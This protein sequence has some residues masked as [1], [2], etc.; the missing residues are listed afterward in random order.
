V[1]DIGPQGPKEPEN[2]AKG[3][4]AG[5][6]G[7]IHRPGGEAGMVHLPATLF[8]GTAGT[9]NEGN[10]MAPVGQEL[11]FLKNANL[12]AAPS[13]RGLGMQNVEKLQIKGT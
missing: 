9:A 11:T 12:L 8:Q 10:P 13:R 1:Q 6:T 4:R 7:H 5:G 3:S 2:G